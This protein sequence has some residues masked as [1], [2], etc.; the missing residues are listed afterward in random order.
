MF[1]IRLSDPLWANPW[2]L[3][4]NNDQIF[5]ILVVLGIVGCTV[6]IYDTFQMVVF[7]ISNR[8]ML[9]GGEFFLVT[10]PTHRIQTH[11]YSPYVYIH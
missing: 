6:S 10:G 11:T 2:A 4:D 1:G 5:N 3:S 7:K 9:G 8:M